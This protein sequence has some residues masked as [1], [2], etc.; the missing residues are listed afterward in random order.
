M[1]KEMLINVA[2]GEEC[3]IAVVQDGHLEGLFLERSGTE[4]HVGNIYKGRVVNVEPS[5][6]AAFV[7]I[8]MPR[9][10][11]LHVSDICGRAYPKRLRQQL[12]GNGK[13]RRKQRTIQQILRPGDEV[14]IQI[15]KEGI[16]TK[17]SSLTTFLSIPGRYLVLMPGL[18]RLGVSRKIEDEDKRKKLR[19]LLAS[20]DP[21]KDLG[22]IV[23]TAGQGRG[24]RDLRRDMNYLTRLWKVVLGR[25]RSAKP[26]A[27]IFRESDLVVRTLR[28]IFT[29]DVEAIWVDSE[30]VLKRVQD[31]L[32][33]AMP[34]QKG[35]AKLYEDETPLF[36]KYRIEEA[37]EAVFSRTVNLPKGGTLVFDQ[38]EA[39]V[40]IDVNSGS[41]RHGKNAEESAKELNLMAAREIARQLRL[42]DLGGVIVIDFVDMEKAEN[43]RAV[44]KAL[45]EAMKDDR[46]RHRMLR[47]SQFGIVEMTRQRV[48]PSLQRAAYTDCPTC[49]GAG[50]V[51]TAASMGLD[52][53]REVQLLAG[54][55]P[56]HTIEVTV[57]TSVADYINNNRR[58]TLVG[59]EQSQEKTVRIAADP[60]S[61]VDRANYRCLDERGIEVNPT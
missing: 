29:S 43:R 20:L 18:S 41:F 48:Q 19:E 55:D 26:P 4:R 36:H 1:P 6:Q 3:R 44:E 28:D 23:R 30:A 38:T 37:I 27:E 24:K 17:G 56:V 53:M 32:K 15:T 2:E 39:L 46:A 8:G 9:N 25:A 51:K 16:G 22:L 45:R 52:V 10:G 59:I 11:F 7:D 57:H 49:K 21:P 40:A 14:V 58:E 60:A 54:R 12:K 34:R 31:F 50:V 35:V 5:I 13:G 33:I 47:M 42:R 61:P